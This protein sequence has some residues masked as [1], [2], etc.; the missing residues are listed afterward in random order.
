MQTEMTLSTM[1]E[2]LKITETGCKYVINK[3]VSKQ[4]HA[5]PKLRC[6]V[7]ALIKF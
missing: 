3:K 5:L 1:K 7:Y 6:C 4:K 2:K